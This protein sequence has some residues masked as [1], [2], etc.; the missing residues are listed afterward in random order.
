MGVVIL[1]EHIKRDF[2]KWIDFIYFRGDFLCM[3]TGRSY[4]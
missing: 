3:K 4:G 2:S 1:L